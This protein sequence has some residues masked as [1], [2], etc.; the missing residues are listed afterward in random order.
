M[1][2][3]P[4]PL[5]SFG[6]SSDGP[7]DPRTI[8]HELRTPVNHIIGYSEMLLDEAADEQRE[9]LAPGLRQIVALG[10]QILAQINGDLIGDEQIDL[11]EGL[12]QIRQALQTPLDEV[13]AL[14]QGLDALVQ[15]HGPAQASAD[16]HKITQAAQRLMTLINEELSLA[17]ASGGGSAVPLI[18]PPREPRPGS[19]EGHLLV[20]DDNEMN[21]DML[22]RRLERL[23]YTTEQAE[24]GR[25][26]LELVA[27]QP[28]DLILLDLMMPEM[29]GY[30]TL[31]RLKA[32]ERQRHIPVIVLSALDEIASVVKCIE[33][34]A[35]DHLLK[36]FD[37]V[38]LQARIGAC[39]EKKRLH[40]RSAAY[41]QQIEREK[42]RADDLLHVVI[43]I[44][45]AL[46]AEK[47]FDALLERI[48]LEAQRLCGADGGTLYLRT[49][50]QTLRFV[51]IRNHSLGIELGG[52]TG[53]PP[54]FAPLRLYDEQGR[55]NTHYVVAACALSGQSFNIADAYHAEG[56]DFSGTRAFDSMT[57]YRTTSLLNVPLTDERGAVIGVLQLLN[58]LD[59]ATGA[60]VAFDDGQQMMVESLST[61]AS[62]AL[63]AYARERQL[64]QQIEDLRI[65]IDEARKARQVAEITDT[66]YFQNLREK[67]RK[68]RQQS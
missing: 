38:L 31:E 5:E 66:E 57:G 60:T 43:P 63:A 62:V 33:I 23:G 65:E 25:Q 68:L 15:Q 30:E 17:Q 2:E 13:V 64:R 44:G 20:V 67:A 45:V 34:G 29:N 35:E 24:N 12:A 55:P 16:L 41:L 61:L 53:L 49:P 14:G 1:N 39:L 42:K 32:D 51:I 37:P 18:S 59:P 6:A 8:R 21:R 9:D 40:D 46:S 50:D 19:A 11:V 3:R 27:A 47:D 48:V 58:A 54:N 36:P 26:A 22:C 10:K 7:I 4:P 28:F 56:F 52:T